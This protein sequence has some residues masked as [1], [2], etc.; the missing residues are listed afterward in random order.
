MCVFNYI[1][2]LYYRKGN[3]RQIGQFFPGVPL[4]CQIFYRFCNISLYM[5]INDNSNDPD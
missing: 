2:E 4:N 1:S 3:R 5:Y